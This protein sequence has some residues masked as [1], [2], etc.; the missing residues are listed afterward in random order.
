MILVILLVAVGILV[1]DFYI[2]NTYVRPGAVLWSVIYWVPSALFVLLSV[3]ALARKRFNASWMNMLVTLLLGVALPKALFALVAWLGERWASVLPWAQPLGY[4]AGLAIAVTVMTL[5]F[6]GI[7]VGWKMVIVRRVELL[8]DTLPV[9]FDG[10]KVAQLTDFH[11]GTYRNSPATV[12]KIVRKVNQLCPDVVVFTGDLVNLR[13]TEIDPFMPILSDMLTPDGV[14]SI[15][16]NHD[17]CPYVRYDRMDG[18]AR[19]TAEICHKE[20]E[21]GWHLL[22]NQ[23]AVIRR[24]DAE[25]AIVGVENEG[26]PPFPARA[27]LT[28]ATKG[29]PEGIFKIL[30]THDPSHWRREVLTDTDIPL[31]LAGHTHGMQFRLGPL[32]PSRFVYPEWGGLYSRGGQKL[33]VSTGIGSNLTFRFGAWPEIVLF[34]LRSGRKV[35]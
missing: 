25:I 18:A 13:P 32:S 29:L 8:F 11:I 2:W 26:K 34:T 16:G 15:L 12:S 14:F 19:A 7:Y 35:Q 6:F 9:E 10:Y 24:K 22:L 3:Y 20:R 31:T 27:D 21:M 30:L 1:P 28:A 17:Y 23:H 33:Y 4:Y 5:S